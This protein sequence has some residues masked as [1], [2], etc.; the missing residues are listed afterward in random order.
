M[1]RGESRE[2]HTIMYAGRQKATFQ[3]ANLNIPEWLGTI[4]ATSAYLTT[5]PSCFSKLYLPNSIFQW[6]IQYVLAIL[7]WVWSGGHHG[8]TQ[9]CHTYASLVYGMQTE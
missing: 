6:A 4:I 1:R 2:I 9:H 5:S 8:N 7:R 3:W